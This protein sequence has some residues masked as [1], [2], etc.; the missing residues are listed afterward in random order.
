MSCELVPQL[1]GREPERL[2]FARVRFDSI[3][4]DPRSPQLAGSVPAMHQA[5]V[6]AKNAH[7]HCVHPGWLS[8]RTQRQKVCGLWMFSC[9]SLVVG[10]FA[11]CIRPIRC[12]SCQ[13]KLLESGEPLTRKAQG[14]SGTETPE[15]LPISS[16]PCTA[17]SNLQILNACRG[18][19]SQSAKPSS[20]ASLHGKACSVGM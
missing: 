19:N 10:I 17:I 12:S 8:P 16:I 15:P 18:V 4:K 6:S 20:M 9:L 2:L 7:A 14:I 11:V 5:D 3:G 13:G 1:M